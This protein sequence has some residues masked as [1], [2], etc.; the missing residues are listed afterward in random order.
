MV[1]TSL[2]C[3]NKKIHSV[4]NLTFVKGMF[5]FFSLKYS[6]IGSIEE[7]VLIL[8]SLFN[9]LNKKKVEYAQIKKGQL[10]YP[11]LGKMGKYL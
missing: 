10:A 6:D 4:K 1:V 2:K 3:L 11:Q 5:L 8:N 7:F 9:T